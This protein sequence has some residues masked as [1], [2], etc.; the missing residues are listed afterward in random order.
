MAHSRRWVKKEA[1]EN[2]GYEK[3]DDYY[4]FTDKVS[5]KSVAIKGIDSEEL[6]MLAVYAGANS[7]WRIKDIEIDGMTCVAA[8][9]WEK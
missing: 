2:E 4:V 7:T 6:E 3:V 1:K 5:K 9:P 8:S